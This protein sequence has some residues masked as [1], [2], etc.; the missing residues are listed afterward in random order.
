[1]T[2]CLNAVYVTKYHFNPKYIA[3]RENGRILLSEKF[4]VGRI[5]RNHNPVVSPLFHLYTVR[6]IDGETPFCY[7]ASFTHILLPRLICAALD[8]QDGK[9]TFV[10]GGARLVLWTELEDTCANRFVLLNPVY[11]VSQGAEY[12]DRIKYDN[13]HS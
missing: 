5:F 4:G 2:S 11:P 1:M 6:A 9:Y 10:T 3:F 8:H 13:K 12:L 7:I